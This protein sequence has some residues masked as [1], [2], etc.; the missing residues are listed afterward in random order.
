MRITEVDDT[1]DQGN[2]VAD[3]LSLSTIGSLTR[4]LTHHG[5]TTGRRSRP[6]TT[7]RSKSRQNNDADAV[8][9]DRL[10]LL[11]KYGESEASLGIDT[12]PY[13]IHGRMMG[14]KLTTRNRRKKLFRIIDQVK[15]KE[16][17]HFAFDAERLKA[18]QK[19]SA[20][21][22]LRSAG[23]YEKNLR[24]MVDARCRNPKYMVT[25][26]IFDQ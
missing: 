17:E 16:N 24:R 23:A 12:Q 2:D 6:Q 11:N 21:V 15:V 19:E 10:L 13:Q 9:P 5:N 26:C 18:K 7:K 22:M 14:W 20:R 8:Q 3:D 25:R 4:K 1:G